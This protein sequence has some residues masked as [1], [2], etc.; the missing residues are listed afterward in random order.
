MNKVQ[1]L[2]SDHSAVS[3][4]EVTK[5]HKTKRDKSEEGQRV[6]KICLEE[7]I[8]EIEALENLT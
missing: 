1:P 5:R 7:E 3:L 8:S 4:V 6:C 2:E